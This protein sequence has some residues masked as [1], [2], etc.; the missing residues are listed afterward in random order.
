MA[1]RYRLYPTAAQV[2]V[3]AVHCRDARFVWNLARERANCWRPGRPAPPGSGQRFGQLAEARGDGFLGAGSS[4]VRQQALRDFDQALR[5]RWAG[6]H[7]RPTW[8][9]RGRHEGVCV[10]DVPV[11][12]LDRT[13]ARL[14]IPKLG[15]VRF[16]LSRPPPADFGMARVTLDRAGR[17]HVAFAAPQPPVARRATGRAAGVDRGVTTTLVDSNGQHHRAPTSPRLYATSDRLSRRLA[18]QR[19]GSRRRAH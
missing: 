19:R 9:K 7:R 2:E 17:W 11:E 8:R 15:W 4:S 13:W 18:R 12:R 10:R 5:N 6:T 14:Q 1:H 3:L 16:R